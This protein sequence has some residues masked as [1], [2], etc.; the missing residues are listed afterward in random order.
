MRSIVKRSAAFLTPLGP[1]LDGLRRPS[2]TS[3]IISILTGAVTVGCAS[4]LTPAAV[5]QIIRWHQQ[6]VFGF[7]SDVYTATADALALAASDSSDRAVVLLGASTTRES[8]HDEDLAAMLR[9]VHGTRTIVHNL[10][11]SE[12]HV[13]ETVALADAIPAN[14]TGTIIIGVNPVRIG[15]REDIATMITSPRIGVTSAAFDEELRQWGAVPPERT[16]L[17]AWDNRRFLLALWS[18]I[19]PTLPKLAAKWAIGRLTPTKPKRHL[20]IGRP[21]NTEAWLHKNF[22]EVA[23][24]VAAYDAVADQSLATLR[25]LAH[26]L[27]DRRHKVVLLEAPINPKFVRESLGLDFYTKHLHRMR[28]FAAAYGIT[29]LNL[30]EL[31]PLGSDAFYDWAHLRSR[32]AQKA[33]TAAVAVQIASFAQAGGEL[34]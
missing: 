24:S 33:Y 34:Q 30:H 5:V 26:R 16:G 20:Y 6:Y 17:Y 11:S 25:R 14:V 1:F 18:W 19:A 21:A 32:S 31:V 22:Q 9:D 13:I 23:A 4:L 3:V 12:Q 2:L 15:Q 29:Y 7:S 10:T 28:S 8:V 27:R